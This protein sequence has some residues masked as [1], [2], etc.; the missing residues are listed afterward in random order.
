MLLIKVVFI[1]YGDDMEK[2]YKIIGN[3]IRRIR[4][5]QGLTIQNIS[6][7]TDTDW[8]FLARIETGKGI[9]SIATI[10]KIAGALNIEA[11]ELFIEKQ[12]D[13]KILDKNIINT[14]NSYPT[15]SKKT[16]LDI[17]K[18]IKTLKK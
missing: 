1:V 8:S 11:Y 2:T 12:S 15:E 4:E 14:I 9:P 10:Y 18:L 5:L 16:I 13:N 6:D 3:N 7:I 17:I